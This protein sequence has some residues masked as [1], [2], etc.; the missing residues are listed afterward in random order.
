MASVIG[1]KSIPVT[2]LVR[3]PEVV[4]EI[5]TYHRHPK[6]LS[7][8]PLPPTI[9]ATTDPREAL[10]DASFIIHAVPVQV[11]EERYCQQ[12]YYYYNWWCC[13]FF[14]PSCNSYLPLVRECG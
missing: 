9:R 4:A 10:N 3:K 6:Y 8:I 13:C 11:G 5:N 12:D 2:I 7:D 1:K 14:P